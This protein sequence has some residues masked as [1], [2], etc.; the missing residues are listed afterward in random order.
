[1]ERVADRD[2]KEA[3]QGRHEEEDHQLA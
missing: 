2:E 1:M 3:S